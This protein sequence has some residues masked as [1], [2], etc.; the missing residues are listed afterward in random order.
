MIRIPPILLLAALGSIAF[1]CVS[2]VHFSAGI[3]E[4]LPSDLAEVQGMN[5]LNEYFSRNGQLIVTVKTGEGYF[6]EEATLE[7]A[8][9]LRSESDLVGEVYQELAL[10]RLATEGG[11]M[12]AWMWL[13]SPPG[14]VAALAERLEKGKSSATIARS[15]DSVQEGLLSGE[16]V[17]AGYDPLALAKLPGALGEVD[18]AETDPMASPDGLFRILYVEGNGVDFSDYRQAAVWL[19]QLKESVELW[20][21]KWAADNTDI[22]IGLT[23]TPAFMAEVGTEME[24][25]MTLSMVGTMLLIAL[26]FW[27]MHRQAK[28]L[29]WLIAAMLVVL[30]ITIL[31][32]GAVFGDLS[33]MSA[34]FGAILIGL[35]VDYGIVIYRESLV[36]NKSA[37]ELRRTV[38]P[39]ILWAAGTT[40]VVFL[41]L[42]FSSLPGIAELGNLV[43]IGIFVGATVMLWG[44]APVAV[45]FSRTAKERRFGWKMGRVTTGRVAAILA[46]GIPAV[47]AVS[48]LFK[49]MPG[50]EAQFHP[51]RIR[52]SQSVMAWG[53]LQN[54]LK[55]RKDAI[56]V[57]ITGS[58]IS[59]LRKNL[60]SAEQRIVKAE[61]DGQ[62]KSHILPTAM[63]PNP[64]FQRTN[65]AIL[66]PLLAESERLLAE[67][68]AAGF[69]KD[70]STLTTEMFDSWER[71][72][73]EIAANDFALPHGR[74]AEWSLGRLFTEKDG[75]F[76]ALGTVKP[77]DRL[78]R[79]WVLAICDDN[80]SAASLGSLGTALN[81][82][83]RGDLKR[84]FIPMICALAI[85]LG[86]VFRS[87]IDLA[88]SLFCL[89][90]SAAAIVI[91]TV[92]TPVS[93]NSFNI[94]GLPLLFGTGLDF[95]IHMIFALRRCGGDLKIARRGI[96]KALVFCGISSAIGFGS[97]AISAADGLS[98]LG[99][100]CGIGIFINMIVAV[101]L[102]PRWYRWM[103]RL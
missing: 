29:S 99:I 1:F 23:G 67:I 59:D 76:A 69:S 53:E 28:P 55:G 31:I 16:S 49:E 45:E 87:A 58:T 35:A 39:G 100:V 70:G 10:D 48:V 96:G 41:S 61:A 38:G 30:S 3:Y 52:E 77:A 5:D 46:F 43:A 64:A 89:A 15:M 97:L 11:S 80:T 103:H 32:A 81:E 54:Q 2:R 102:L 101:W 86:I 24:R 42:N 62:L 63:V 90:F 26:L 33:V 72:L 78:K 47:A 34:G 57:S 56:P 92:W 6:T 17:I 82:R 94:C 71:A 27:I 95:S 19:N 36:G 88:L 21:I 44:F 85:M 37:K 40:A 93:W 22:S 65:A 98:S 68:D 7:L 73:P 9:H 4:L 20:R 51:F 91:L 79:D 84:V 12:L 14:D 60:I 83:I 74:L 66:K 8:E 50:L 25:D 75:T 13:N 18:L